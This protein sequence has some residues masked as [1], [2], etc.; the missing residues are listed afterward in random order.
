MVNFED[1]QGFAI[2]ASDERLPRVFA[3]TES[4]SLDLSQPIENPG[5]EIFVN[6]LGVMMAAGIM[7]IESA[8]PDPN[9]PD[10]VIGYQPWTNFNIRGPFISVQWDQGPPYNKYSQ[11][12]AGCVPIAVAQIMA[13]HEFPT[14]HNG[15]TFDWSEMKKHTNSL[16][17]SYPSAHELIAVF[18]QQ[19]SS[20][21]NLRATGI[22]GA[23][24]VD[25]VYA[26]FF[27]LGYSLRPVSQTNSWGFVSYSNEQVLTSLSESNPSYARG[28]SQGGTGGGHAWVIDG[29][30][31]QQRIKHRYSI[32]VEPHF[33]D[34][35][36]IEY[37][38]LVHCNWGWAGAGNGFYFSGVFDPINGPKEVNE[39]LG[40]SWSV[41]AN[42]TFT[43]I[44]LLPIIK[45]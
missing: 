30:L 17:N 23:V 20:H 26:T 41:G 35:Y 42:R 45:R 31:T 1:E 32:R 12:N 9:D 44:Q 14:S 27:R 25:R 19:I 6:N 4:G 21:N 7:P 3:L 18:I 37:R 5:L 24:S 11:M 39:N 40:E 15:Y 28:D 29:C 33:P 8:D 22:Y 43:D 10:A 13:Y 16:T 36:T 2:L 38:E 34:E